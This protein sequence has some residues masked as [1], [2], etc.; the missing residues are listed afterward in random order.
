V[1][2]PERETA[3]VAVP[4]ADENARGDTSARARHPGTKSLSATAVGRSR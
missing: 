1:L 2:S 3:I 4:L